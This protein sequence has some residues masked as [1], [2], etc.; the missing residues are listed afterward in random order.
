MTNMLYSSGGALFE[1]LCIHMSSYS[2][3]QSHNVMFLIIQLSYSMTSLLLHGDDITW[4]T[5]AQC[6]TWLRTRRVPV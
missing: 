5:L 1:A 3:T 2:H 6:K 4:L